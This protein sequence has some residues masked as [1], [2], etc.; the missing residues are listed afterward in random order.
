MSG[1]VIHAT[2]LIPTF[3]RVALLHQTLTSLARLRTSDALTWE[4]LV[5]DN[6]TDDEALS[7]PVE[8]FCA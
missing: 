5:I 6:N 7:A 3:N 2:V 4:V 8:A 1:D